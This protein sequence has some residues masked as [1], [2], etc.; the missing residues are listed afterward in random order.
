MVAPRKKISIGNI[1]KNQMIH[2]YYKV[3][4]HCFSVEADETVFSHMADYEPFLV[5]EASELVFTVT[6]TMAKHVD[7]EYTE[8]ARSNIDTLTTI[9]GEDANG[10]DVYEYFWCG[11]TLF[12]LVCD[13]Q[14]RHGELTLT[15]VQMKMSL[16]FAITNIYRYATLKLMT[17]AI[18]ASAVSYKGRAYLFL[19]IS[20]TGKSTHS[21]LWLKYF[22]GTELINDDKPILRVMENGEVRLYGSP[23]SGKTPCYRN[24]EYPVGGMV[25]L[26]QAPHN[27]IR[28][29]GKVETYY[30]ILQSVYGK[31]WDK[32]VS[33]LLHDYETKLVELVPMWHLE[34]LPDQA[35]AELSKKTVTG[36]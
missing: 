10:Q 2:K 24:V 25:K 23:W 17:A 13:K 31:R 28:R 16:D 8:V 6:V 32:A 35:A 36:E 22:E 15:G 20:G 18:H 3:G 21:R 19:G 30:V 9:S 29:L 33:T 1:Q 14:Y 7:F 34:C 27:K 11:Q 4:G 26:N 12:W 5:N